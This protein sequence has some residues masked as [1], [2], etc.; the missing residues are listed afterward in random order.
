MK[1]Q[2]FVRMS[3]QE[4]QRLVQS[5]AA[6]TISP[7][8]QDEMAIPT[9]L[10]PNPLIR[11]LF[12]K[13]YEIIFDI[14]LNHAHSQVSILEFGCGIGVFLPDLCRIAAQ[15]Y[16]IDLFPQV[17]QGLAKERALPVRFVNHLGEIPNQGLDAIVAA[18]VMEHVENPQALAD[19]FWGKLRSGGWLV[20]SGPTES[21]LYQVGRWL[22]G[23]AG[24]GDYHHTNIIQLEKMIQNSRF[25][26]IEKHSL[27]LP[28]PLCLFKIIAFQKS[29]Q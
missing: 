2:A 25:R 23:F 18:D 28:A 8:T 1:Q 12:W 22:A 4:I 5:Y 20:I 19:E 24:K 6:R 10:H 13:R 26:V 3:Q 29:D 16:A 17:A 9:Y 7:A 21:G 27:P 11:W 14:L 15:V